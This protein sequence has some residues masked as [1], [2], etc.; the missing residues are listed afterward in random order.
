MAVNP[1]I[2][3][4]L[5]QL[6]Q[7]PQPPIDQIS[8]EEY[9]KQSNQTLTYNSG[10][11]EHVNRIVD[12]SLPLSGRDIPVRIYTPDSQKLLPAL[13]FYHGGGFVLGDL[14]SH[15]AICRY[16]ANSIHCVVISVD[17]RLAP[18]H[19]FPAAVDDAY[20]SLKWI[21]DHPEEF[22][23]DHKRIAVG[24]DS[25]GG[26][27]AAVAALI[28]KE[29]RTPSLLHQLLIYPSTGYE[30]EP[31]SIRENAEGYF[32]TKDMM[33]WFRM[34]YFKDDQDFKHPYASPILHPDLTGLP[35]ATILTAQYDPLRD[36]GKAYADKLEESGVPVTYKNYEDLIHGFANFIGFV[37]EAADALKDGAESLKRAFE[38]VDI[39]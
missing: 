38:T 26:N 31:P 30:Q 27:L 35:P 29:K 4:F 14:E 5:D 39:I 34:H 23:I 28:A 3:Y 13:I 2:Q 21:A 17:Y 19:P 11:P 36:V 6:K 16:L 37:P 24:G 8:P 20:D 32:L 10:E 15:D 18:E 12:R 9:R 22:Q 1:K 33:N 7:N 25:A